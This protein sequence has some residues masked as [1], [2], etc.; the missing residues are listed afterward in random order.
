MPS[1]HKSWS[2]TIYPGG[3]KTHVRIGVYPGVGLADARD[4]H[5]RLRLAVQDGHDPGKERKQREVAN[6]FTFEKLAAQYLER[7]SK[8]KKKSWQADA[9]MLRSFVLPEL[10]HMVADRITRRDIIGVLNKK[11]FGEDG[12]GGHPIQ[13]NRG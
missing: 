1:G 7:H 5:V 4:K 6:A 10:G 11:A 3:R 8:I 9:I 2:S 12:K 13:A